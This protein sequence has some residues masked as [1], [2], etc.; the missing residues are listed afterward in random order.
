MSHTYAVVVVTFNPLMNL[1]FLKLL[2]NVFTE[3]ERKN[4]SINVNT[5]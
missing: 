3:L 4:R 5:A 2:E 1:L